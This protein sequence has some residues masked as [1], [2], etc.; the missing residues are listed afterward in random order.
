MYDEAPEQP[1]SQDERPT[2]LRNRR[3]GEVEDKDIQ[4]IIHVL[5]AEAE[6]RVAWRV[7]IEQRWIEDLQ[8]Y[9]GIYPDH[10]RAKLDKK[11]NRSSL[12]V[13]LTGPKTDAM[14]ARLMDLIFPTDDRSWGIGPTP[15][16]EMDQI[17]KEG[18]DQHDKAKKTMS[19][20]DDRLQM[21]GL[22]EPEKAELSAMGQEAEAQL[23]EA[24]IALDELAELKEKARRASDL[25][26]EEIDDQLKASRYQAK[27][28]DVIDDACK[29]GTGIM[30]GPV[31]TEKTNKR[32]QADEQG[33]HALTDVMEM[34]PGYE[35]VDPWGFFPDPNARNI[36]ECEDFFERHLLN[37]K[38]MRAMAKRPDMDE[39]AIAKVLDSGPGDATPQGMNQLFSLTKDDNHQIKDKYQVWE[40]TGPID[41][42][43]FGTLVEAYQD[44]DALEVAEELDSLSEL[45][46]KVWFCQG[47]VLKFA[48]HPLESNESIYSVFNIKK[49]ESSLFGYGIPYLARDP[50]AS[51]NAAWR[52]MMDNAAF[53]AGP[54]VVVNRN[55]IKPEHNRQ[56][57]DLEAFKVWQA[58]DG[59]IDSPAFE[60]YQFDMNQPLL[61]GI[62][63]M[64]RRDL[65]EMTSMPQIAQGEQGA[66]VTK[67]AQ[68]MAMLMN[69]ANVNFRRVVKNWDDDMAVPNIRRIYDFNMQY[70]SKEEI[71]GDYEVDARGSSVLLVREMQSTNLMNY[72]TMFADNPRW[73]AW[74][75]EDGLM[76]EIAK[77]SM[78][79][80]DSIL[81]TRDEV[82]KDRAEAGKQQDPMAQ[83]EMAKQ[84]L[85]M[86]K[87]EVM[88]ERI[89]A[90]IAIAEME[91]A[92]RVE[93][94]KLTYS[95]KM[96]SVAANLNA[97]DEDL[98]I[99]QKIASEIAQVK[100]ATASEE[101]ARKE[102]AL[103]TEVAVKA[104]TG[105]SAGGNI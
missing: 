59:A 87:L 78:I 98:S 46:V 67:T 62:I 44:V 93:A 94:A 104:Q 76:R 99:K 81:K 97:K 20:V 56:G 63:E 57:Y 71:K 65:D 5:R 89:E 73:S 91:T 48:I 10:I 66:G 88:R 29:M 74:I 77:V 34:R 96:E 90:D 100:A 25:M 21:D 54:Q 45:H 40:F 43:H 32:W 52:M 22:S 7:M 61:Q 4:Q 105:D 47:E 15:V 16:P 17:Q 82:E 92:S 33:Q 11:K 60:T 49:S 24:Q 86:A 38:Q 102:R 72:A 2:K 31:L 64:S 37:A 95:A 28:R 18:K 42:E 35:R 8:Q 85:E 1:Q 75:K 39:A 6:L 103:A 19:E 53:A 26:Q 83:V 69:S 23:S 41:K 27:C 51:I 84:E 36:E 58:V 3:R 79:S 12:F 80:T 55:R 9:H 14:S 50:Q 101:V 13:N 30:K 68:G 70:S